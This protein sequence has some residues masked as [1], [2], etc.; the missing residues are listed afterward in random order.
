MNKKYKKY[1]RL[2]MPDQRKENKLSL[3][4][5]LGLAGAVFGIIGSCFGAY[6]WIET[7]YVPREIHKKDL[8]TVNTRMDHRDIVQK[9][10][11]VEIDL[12]ITRLELEKYLETPE[13]ERSESEKHQIRILEAKE[14]FLQEHLFDGK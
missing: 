10:R 11:V 12:K 2:K 4:I 6:N 1:L 13:E 7:H 8:E 14:N 3:G 5:A 9:N